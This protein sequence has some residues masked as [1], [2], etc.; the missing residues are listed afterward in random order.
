MELDNKFGMNASKKIISGS[1][2]TPSV[3]TVG[4]TCWMGRTINHPNFPF[5]LHFSAYWLSKGV[6]VDFYPA[7]LK[8]RVKN[9]K[10][11]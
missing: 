11:K 4:I 2:Y 10:R 1:F 5:T 9:L 6:R 8:S 7:E 3:W